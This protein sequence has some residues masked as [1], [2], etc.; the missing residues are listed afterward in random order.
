MQ[1]KRQKN[2]EANFEMPKISHVKFCMVGQNNFTF[3]SIQN[4]FTPLLLFSQTAKI[5]FSLLKDFC[6]AFIL[7][8]PV[9][10]ILM[11]YDKS[12]YEFLARNWLNF[13]SGIKK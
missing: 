5:S 11:T 1:K 7:D 4:L 2:W 10:M 8:H 12:Y 9:V 13:H 3:F 6:V